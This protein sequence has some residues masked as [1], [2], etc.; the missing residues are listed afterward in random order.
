MS[1]IVYL[2]FAIVGLLALILHSLMD[3]GARLAKISYRLAQPDELMDDK[4]VEAIED[5][6]YITAPVETE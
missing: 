2:L 5:S 1:M 6:R 3:I 4:E